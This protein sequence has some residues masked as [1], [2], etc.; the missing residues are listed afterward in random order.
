MR[1]LK[2][3][4][5]LYCVANI[6]YIGVRSGFAQTPSLNTL[7]ESE[8]SHSISLTAGSSYFSAPDSVRISSLPDR[9]MEISALPPIGIDLGYQKFENGTEL[10][11]IVTE[12]ENNYTL[13]RQDDGYGFV[14]FAA[15]VGIQRLN[16]AWEGQ[17]QKGNRSVVHIEDVSRLP[18]KQNVTG[19]DGVSAEDLATKISFQTQQ[20]AKLDKWQ[21][22]RHILRVE[23]TPVTVN[24]EDFLLRSFIIERKLSKNNKLVSS[25][26]ETYIPVL[27]MLHQYQQVSPKPDGWIFT[28]YIVSEK[29]LQMLQKANLE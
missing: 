16:I 28:N 9:A 26:E 18:V 29:R 17:N 11:W 3:L 20:D 12:K 8:S 15:F 21:V 19:M 4:L 24:G 14:F 5:I 13:V 23:V 27:G 2:L 10:E 25:G 22:T 1:K 7:G 6:C